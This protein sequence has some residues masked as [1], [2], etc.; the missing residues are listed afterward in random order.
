MF[1]ILKSLFNLLNILQ[2]FNIYRRSI[3]KKIRGPIRS[4]HK[5]EQKCCGTPDLGCAEPDPTSRIKTARMVA[6]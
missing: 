3:N 5:W 4:S 1:G 6:L 2:C